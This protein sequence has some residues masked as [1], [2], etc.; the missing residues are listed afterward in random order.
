M[1]QLIELNDLLPNPYQPEGRLVVKPEKAREFA[2]SFQKSG[3]IQMPIVRES[4]SVL[5][6]YEVADGWQRK[7]GAEYAIRELGLLQFQELACVVKNLT[8]QEMADMIIETT[9]I[10]RDM[11]VIERA[12]YYRKYFSQFPGVTQQAFAE[13]HNRSQSEIANTLRLLEL[14]EEIQ[15]LIISQE[16]T[17]THG[18]SL[19]QL[20]EREKI[21]EMAA[22]IISEHMTVKETDEAIKRLI[23]EQ[24]PKMEIPAE[25]T[26]APKVEE[27]QAPNEAGEREPV[28]E[29]EKIDERI[30]TGGLTEAAALAG[31][32]VKV[33]DLTGAE[34]AETRPV[35]QPKT[36]AGGKAVDIMPQKPVTTRPQEPVKTQAQKTKNGAPWEPLSSFNKAK[37][38][39]EKKFT[40]RLILQERDEGVSAELSIYEERNINTGDDTFELNYKPV[41]TY[42]RE[43]LFE[44]STMEDILDSDMDVTVLFFLTVCMEDWEK[45]NEPNERV[46]EPNERVREP[47]ERV[48]ESNEQVRE[49]KHAEVET[50]MPIPEGVRMDE[51]VPPE[52]CDNCDLQV[53]DHTIGMKFREPG[54]E[55]AYLKVCVKDYRK[56]EKERGY[57][58]SGKVIAQQDDAE[59]EP[60][61]EPEDD[62]AIL[63]DSKMGAIIQHSY[64]ASSIGGKPPSTVSS[65]FKYENRLYVNTSASSKVGRK[66][67]EYECYRLGEIVDFKGRVYE[68]QD[69]KRPEDPKKGFYH[70]VKV[71]FGDSCHVLVGPP[72]IFREVEEAGK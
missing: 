15:T 57:D 72:L 40:R 50:I 2:L 37:T 24:N 6:A 25:N 34:P 18:R 59:E 28:R 27:A 39:P 69:T 45:K 68:F 66:G 58:I 52:E 4:P 32:K 71:Y 16:I 22:W 10:R 11:N 19:L 63:I 13:R 67:W 62:G 21:I 9:D 54:K 23:D 31:A 29:L 46:R 41:K 26:Q 56:W 47:N 20:K 51:E 61:E 38:E 8:D 35:E 30:P 12:Q 3:I 5:G 33:V 14:P 7:A 70:G 43:Y 1:V 65:P 53:S 44:E 64:S 60:E 49:S 36:E 55:H 17:E 42:K 48:R